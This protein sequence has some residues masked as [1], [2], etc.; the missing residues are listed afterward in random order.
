MPAGP[1][2]RSVV[3]PA[4]GQAR[5]TQACLRRLQASELQRTEIV[6]VE[7]GATGL[8]LD[9]AGP[10]P[11][12][13]VR[14]AEQSGFAAACN[15]GAAAAQGRELVFL[16]NDTLPSEGWLDALSRC[17]RDHPGT[18]IVGAKL[19]W[20]DDTVQHAGVVFD[21]DGNGLHL[22]E[23]FPARHPAVDKPRELQAVTAAAMLVLREA[24]EAVGGFDAGFVNGWEDVDLCLRAGEQGWKVRYAPDSV[25][26]HLEGATRGREFEGD[27]PNYVAF[28]ERWGDRVCRDAISQL[29]AGRAAEGPPRAGRRGAGDRAG[30]ARGERLERPGRAAR[31][32]DGPRPRAAARQRAAGGGGRTARGCLAR[33]AAQARPREPGH[34]QRGDP[35]RPPRHPGLAAGARS[36]A[37][38]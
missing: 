25:V 36:R 32:A 37:R 9:D 29:G 1:V 38:P 21:G 20:P 19:L 6:V 7:D 2:E 18:G 10:L 26:Y 12:R 13:H 8:E 31:R 27:A 16:N 15:A 35:G 11:V 28:M 33:G 34:P 23:G 3:I 24:F 22:Y 17:A 30:A 14:R 5:L 4:H